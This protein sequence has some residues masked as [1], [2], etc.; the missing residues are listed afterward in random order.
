MSK[1]KPGDLVLTKTYVKVDEV[2]DDNNIVVSDVDKPQ[3]FRIEGKELI[4]ELGSADS[5]D[6]VEKVTL[7]KMA[8]T[9]STSYTTPFTVCF[10][11]Q[12]TDKDI[13]EGKKIGELRKLRGRL[14]APE[15]LLGRSK[16]EDLDLAE[17]SH[18]M[19]LVDHRNINWLIVNGVKYEKGKPRKKK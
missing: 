8:E 18:R 17:G 10:N 6:T 2:R 5:F 19:R 15:P 3:R 9:L 12:L 1:V 11:K 16:V 14:I 13:K 4:D 7:T